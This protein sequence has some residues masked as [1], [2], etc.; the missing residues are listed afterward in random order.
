LIAGITVLFANCKHGDKSRREA[1]FTQNAQTPEEPS[2]VV[3]PPER[4][5]ENEE[6]E[7]D[8]SSKLI[9]SWERECYEVPGMKYRRVDR[10]EVTKDT[11]TYERTIYEDK[12]CVEK[13]SIWKWELNP[14]KVGK[15]IEVTQEGKTLDGFEL[16]ITYDKLT[17]TINSKDKIEDVNNMDEY[18][19]HPGG[20][21]ELNKELDITGESNGDTT[22][23]SR[24]MVD[25]LFVVIDRDAF[26]ITGDDDSKDL[27]AG[28]INTT[29]KT[30]ADRKAEFK[31]VKN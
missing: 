15:K 21:W 14:Y 1:A 24:G 9:G 29:R 3:D 4:D 17:R 22:Q 26:S 16:D 19:G 28:E 30:S 25:R 10:L 5:E 2:R 7:V 27:F 18:Y 8:M 11:M 23:K 31:K 20:D 6:E 12:E 13:N